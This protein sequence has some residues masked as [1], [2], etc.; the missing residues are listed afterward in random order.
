[1]MFSPRLQQWLMP[2]LIISQAIPVFA[3]APLL[4]LWL[5][6]GMA[7]KV[8]M[9]TL[10]IFFPVTASFFDGLR[11]TEPGWLELA[12]TMNAGGLAELRHVRLMAALPSFG[13]G[14]RVA[15][16]VAPIGAIIGEWVGSSSGLG[17]VMLNANARVQ[18]EVCF[19]ALFL[20]AIMAIVLVQLVDISVRKLLYWVPDSSQTR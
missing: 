19:A 2:V 5:G 3:L 20:L 17:Y 10:I 13:S 1:M 14:L 11:R 18:T 12:K 4:V 15:A 7:S 9:A 8:V 6:F 16:A